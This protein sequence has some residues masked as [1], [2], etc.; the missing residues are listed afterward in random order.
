MIGMT[1]PTTT[2]VLFTGEVWFQTSEHE[3]NSFR[4]LIHDVPLHD[5]MFSVCVA[6]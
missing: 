4:T 6:T 2:L 1:D 5:V 3:S